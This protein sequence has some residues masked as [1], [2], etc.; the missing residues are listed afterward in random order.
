M[1]KYKKSKIYTIRSPNTDKFYI[2]STIQYLCQRFASHKSRLYTS[3]K[4]I[5]D[6]GDAYVELLENF[7]CNNKEEL[8]KR[9]GELIRH[10]KDNCINQNMAGRTPKEYVKE[11]KDKI[12]EYNRKR[13]Q[14]NKKVI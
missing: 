13:Y 4:I 9:E 2:G 14:N 11:K 8:N 3:S 1:E 12:N 7:P 6:Y 5:F 10:Y